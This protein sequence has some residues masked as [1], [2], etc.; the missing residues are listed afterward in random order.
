MGNRVCTADACR[1]REVEPA[2]LDS[3]DTWP[4][5][6]SVL[7]RVAVHVDRAVGSGN[8]PSGDP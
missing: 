7:Q 6:E 1:R 3:G 5:S 8:T 4:N 2:G